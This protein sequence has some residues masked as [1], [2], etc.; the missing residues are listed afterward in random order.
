MLRCAFLISAL[1]LANSAAAS[2]AD[3]P[4]SVMVIGTFHWSNPGRDL[5]DVHVDDVLA[6]KRQEEIA[7]MASSLSRFRP[8]KIAVEDSAEDVSQRYGTYLKGTLKPSRNEVVQLGFRLAR[9]NNASVHGIDVEGDFPYDAV[10]TYAK[11]H[12]QEDILAGA[13]KLVV[14]EVADEQRVIDKGTLPSAL[15]WLNEPVREDHENDFNRIAMKIGHG[16]QQPGAELFAA[17]AKRNALI[18]ANLLQLAKPGDRMIVIYGAGHETFL[19]QCVRETPGF[20]LVE[21]NDYLPR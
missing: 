3:K 9:A 14:R 10:Q 7:A 17:W 16:A 19:R 13:D 6:P 15:R 12:G 1:L 18:C 20:K 21:A 4:V 5:H 8:T 11:A 2:A